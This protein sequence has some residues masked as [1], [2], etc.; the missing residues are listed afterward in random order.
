MLDIAIPEDLGIVTDDASILEAYSQDAISVM[1]PGGIARPASIKAMQAIVR[2]CHQNRVPI[3]PCGSQTSMTAA[4][5]SDGG[6]ILSTEKLSSSWRV[7]EDPD[8]PGRWLADT[9]PSVI[10]AKFQD[11]LAEK[12]YFYPPDPT[13]RKDVM[14]GAT[15]ATNASGEDTYKYG[16]TRRWVRALTYIAA[17]GSL[18]KV[19]RPID[20]DGDGVK[21][22]CGFPI[23]GSEIDLL[24]GS[25]GTLGIVVEATVEVLPVVPTYFAILF[26]MPTEEAALKQVKQFHEDP[27]FDLRCL[28]YMDS[29][30]VAILREKGVEVPDGAGAALYVKQEFTDDEDQKMEQWSDALEQVFTELDA[31]EYMEHIHFADDWQSQM[32]LREW[33]HHIPATINER[34]TSYRANGGGKVGT[35]WYV[36]LDKLPE[37]FAKAREDQGDMEWVVFGHIGNG[38]PHFNFVTRNADEYRRGRDL[39]VKHCKLAVSLGGGV[40]GEHGLGKIK[41]HLLEIQYS[42]QDVAGMAAVKKQMDPN[43]IL[44]RGNIFPEH[45]VG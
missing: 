12:G 18:K 39:L 17:D 20:E 16:S 19:T 34:A 38:H 27:S 9:G 8:K 33:R 10:L 40:S 35:D 21:N 31:P 30:A 24:I 5:L 15:I 45:L 14:L 2:W 32:K 13:S 29:G 4:S 42:A 28:E 22:T 23:Q 26:F 41:T 44:G 1:Q 11:A 25:E 36:P 7:Y 43:N 3:T 37:M 6:L